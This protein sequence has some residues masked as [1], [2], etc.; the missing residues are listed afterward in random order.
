MVKR[1]GSK[2]G[3]FLAE[4]ITWFKI[5]RFNYHMQLYKYSSSEI[6]LQPLRQLLKKK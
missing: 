6:K 5:Q 1:I 2:R 4:A 3:S